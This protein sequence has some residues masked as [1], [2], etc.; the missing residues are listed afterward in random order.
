MIPEQVLDEAARRFSLLGDPTRLRILNALHVGGDCS[1]GQIATSTGQSLA[2]VSQH[3]GR[4]LSAGIVRRRR[5]GKVVMYS[6][7]DDT[8]ASL[9]DIVCTSV[10]D[11]AVVLSR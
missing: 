7:A 11:R 1:V 2:N 5:D 3:L 4:L 6:I 10:R 9:C 8:I